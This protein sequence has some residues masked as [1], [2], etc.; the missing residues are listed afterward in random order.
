MHPRKMVKRALGLMQ[1]AGLR[2]I[3]EER[4]ECMCGWVCVCG[5]G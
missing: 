5:V 3:S 2:F 1:P 4:I